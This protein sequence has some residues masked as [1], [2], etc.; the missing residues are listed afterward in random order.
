ML[1]SMNVV[2]VL[3]S[4]LVFVIKGEI[5]RYYPFHSGVFTGCNCFTLLF[6]VDNSSS[7]L[8]PYYSDGCIEYEVKNDKWKM[9][10]F[11]IKPDTFTFTITN[12]TALLVGGWRTPNRAVRVRVRMRTMVMN[13]AVFFIKTLYS[14]SAS[15]HPGINWYRR[16]HC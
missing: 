12:C 10:I 11:K 9:K 5:E 14:H 1:L 4:A 2:T 8:L 13:G 6:I 7:E 3:V 16:I 15:P